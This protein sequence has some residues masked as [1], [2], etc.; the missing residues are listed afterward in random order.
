M[1]SEEISLKELL[2]RSRQ[3][4]LKPF[5]KTQRRLLFVLN[6]SYLGLIL[7]FLV[8]EKLAT[9]HFVP[10]SFLAWV[11]TLVG[12]ANVLSAIY[13]YQW[14]KDNKAVH[15]GDTRFSV[16]P[17]ERLDRAL[18]WSSVVSIML[19]S[20]CHM[21][22]LGNPS[23][24]AI[25]TDFALGHSLIV[26]VAMLLGRTASFVWF[27]IVIGLLVYVSFVD[28]GYSY[29]YNYLTKAESALYESALRQKQPWALARKADL[30]NT[31]LNPPRVSRYF[32]IWLVYIL[33][34]F[35]TSYFFLGI[36]LDVFK[37]VP[38]VTEDIKDAIETTKRQELEHEREKN[39]AEEQ[40]LLLKQETL[41]AELKHLKAQ[42]NPHFLYNTLNYFYIKSLDL[43]EDLSEAIL[44]L[45]NIMRYGMQENQ[46]L[47]S[48]AEEVDYMKQFIVLHQL[49]NGNKLF[50][51][52]TVIGPIDQ[53][54]IL[55][56]LLIGL[57][58]NSFKHGK[59]N[60]A[61]SP[62][63]I[64]LKVTSDQIRFFTSNRKNK[65][66]Q[67]ESNHIGLSNM[68]RRLNLTYEQYLFDIHQDDE[69]FSCTLLI[70][71]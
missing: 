55:P 35:L 50:I 53:K 46:N 61:D 24:D 15:P 33:I 23:S 22:G 34:A 12:I 8:S 10:H 43:S 5:A 19:M 56:F 69:N 36:T 60:T 37:V 58:E 64:E 38:T 9:G 42:L 7:I 65:K 45:S 29:Q 49:R 27:M 63:V 28:K 6:L 66:K 18:R 70:N 4:L 3:Q 30:Q 16:K 14:L 21:I 39:Q 11:Y 2:Q 44:K 51:D 68:R 17:A 31:G 59:M 47:V 20:F 32:N 26:L 57:L 48:L 40:K 25:L 54:Q 1:E 67:V 41:S 52:F 71:T 62:L 13:S